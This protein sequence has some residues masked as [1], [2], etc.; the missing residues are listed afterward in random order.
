M[1]ETE[2][3]PGLFSLRGPGHG[4]GD[5]T[6]LSH[7]PLGNSLWLTAGLELMV[8]AFLFLFFTN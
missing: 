2:P 3:Q 1:E 5:Q 8:H 4:R 7:W 6:C